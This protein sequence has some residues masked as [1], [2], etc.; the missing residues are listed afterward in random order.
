MAGG[1]ALVNIERADAEGDDF[2]RERLGGRELDEFHAVGLAGLPDLWSVGK[3]LVTALDVDRDF[4]RRFEAR[5]VE[6][7]ESAAGVDGG[8]GGEGIP[9]AGYLVAIGAGDGGLIE[10]AAIADRD[11]RVAGADGGREWQKNRFGPNRGVRRDGASLPEDRGGTQFEVLRIHC[12]ELGWLGQ[13]DFD[14]S[15]TGK[16]IAA[17]IDSQ[18]DDVFFGDDVV[19]EEKGLGGQGRGAGEEKEDGFSHLSIMGTLRLSEL[20]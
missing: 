4:P 18:F 15:P 2:G 11:G 8:K 1:G 5:L 3:S 10:L 16:G 17:R 20:S 7:G 14:L 19:G 13:L 6:A 9:I 12:D